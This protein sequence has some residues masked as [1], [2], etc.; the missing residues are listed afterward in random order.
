MLGVHLVLE[1][2]GPPQ[3][4]REPL[5]P[6]PSR[7]GDEAKGRMGLSSSSLSQLGADGLL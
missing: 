6:F 7:L 4:R 1:V 2:R 3:R 5:V